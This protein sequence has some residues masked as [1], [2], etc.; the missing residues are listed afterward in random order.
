MF[1]NVTIDFGG[2]NFPT[3]H[4]EDG[5]QYVGFVAVFSGCSRA[6][7]GNPCPDCQNPSL[8]DFNSVQRYS[9]ADLKEFL[10]RKKK[11]FE[12]VFSAPRTRYVLALLGGEPL[13]QSSDELDSVWYQMVRV[14]GH[15]FQTVCFT[16]YPSLDAIPRASVPFVRD[17]VDYLKLGPYLGNQHKRTGLS[18]GLATENQY[19]VD[20]P[21]A[22]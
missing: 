9:V 21:F 5:I 1:C 18:S 14:F 10:Q 13:D 7:H 20:F 22:E 8:W 17:T 6:A 12:S 16:G 11:N 4:K 15:G 3:P 2:V 19:W